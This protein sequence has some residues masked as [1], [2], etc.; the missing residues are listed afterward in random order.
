MDR[1]ESD[2][3]ITLDELEKKINDIMEDRERLVNSCR[4]LERENQ[5][6]DEQIEDLV[7]ALDS[8]SFIYDSEGSD[9]KHKG[10]DQSVRSEMTKSTC[11]TSTSLSSVSLE[12]EDY[13]NSKF[14]SL[15]RSVSSKMMGGVAEDEHSVMS[16]MESLKSEMTQ[17]TNG[18]SLSSSSIPEHRDDLESIKERLNTN[19]P[20][21]V[22]FLTLMEGSEMAVEPFRSIIEEADEFEESSKEHPDEE[23]LNH[24]EFIVDLVL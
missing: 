8:Q 13:S 18:A 24:D 15:Y 3:K 14:R 16:G 22:E 6:K 4:D 23:N 5:V 9:E 11:A 20:K 7:E 2:E 17:S 21:Y 19:D 10:D 1:P 12:S